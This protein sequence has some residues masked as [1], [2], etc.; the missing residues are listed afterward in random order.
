MCSPVKVASSRYEDVINALFSSARA[1]RRGKGGSAKATCDELQCPN[2]AAARAIISNAGS[3]IELQGISYSRRKVRNTYPTTIGTQSEKKSSVAISFLVAGIRMSGAAPALP[4]ISIHL[5]LPPGTFHIPNTQ[6]HQPIPPY[7]NLPR[8]LSSPI[9]PYPKTRQK[10]IRPG[11][12]LRERIS[13]ICHQFIVDT[14]SF[15]AQPAGPVILDWSALEKH[16]YEIKDAEGCCEDSEEEENPALG[17]A[18]GE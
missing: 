4:L 13:S 7:H 1:S 11:A 2:D 12:F 14:N 10:P 6:N 9:Q 15:F 17:R 3:R 18:I 16:Q 8:H 5:R